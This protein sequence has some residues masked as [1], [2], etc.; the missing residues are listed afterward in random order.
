MIN[1][2]ELEE[3]IKKNNIENVYIMC[4]FNEKLMK[5]SINK[6]LKKSISQDF[7]SL[8][9]SVFDGNEVE[10][11][12]ILNACET[13]PF[14]SE[15]R[16]VV[17][18]RAGFL[19]DNSSGSNKNSDKLIK[20]I[21]KYV[22][23]VP[24]HC[25]LVMY[26]VFDNTRE[27]PSYRVKKFDKK[28]CVVEFSKLRGMQFQKKVKDVF[29][30][31]GKQIGKTELNYF[32]SRVENNM[33]IVYNE[34]EKLCCYTLEKEITKESIDNLLQ[35]NETDDIF[36]LVDY[37]SQSKPEMAITVLNEIMYKGVKAN[38]I[39]YMV[40]RQFKLM[41]SIKIGIENKQSKEALVKELKL[42]P[43]VCDKMI[44]ECKRFTMK[45][46][47]KSLDICLRTEK[48]LK[49]VSGDPKF[50]MEV[51]IINLAII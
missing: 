1:Y 37:I 33:D 18:Y 8:N 19:N 48:E 49:S 28:V 25:I 32:C 50:K 7:E 12:D 10:F 11:E 44:N 43:Y 4:G 34:I 41:L 46:I 39:L 13:V 26:Y 16:M 17:V 5:E 45:K 47:L 38:S 14:M 35:P 40:E 3:N 30:E 9:Y 22:P 15:K 21:E 20:D 6:I 36:N 42:N 51:L 27:K 31:K 2:T 23:N 24:K 29:A